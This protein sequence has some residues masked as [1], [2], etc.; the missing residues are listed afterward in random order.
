[1]QPERPACILDP[2]HRD[3]I[4]VAVVGIYPR[5]AF[6][7][8]V[9][10]SK[11]GGDGDFDRQRHHRGLLRRAHRRAL[12]NFAINGI[13]ISTYLELIIAFASIKQAAALSNRALGLLDETRAKAIVAACEEI[14]AGYLH[15]PFVVDVI[16]GGAGTST[17]MNASEVIANRALELLGHARGGKT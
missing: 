16:Q 5:C 15:D 1:L 11:T 17:N 12:E 4:I 3:G 13:P 9:W 7:N 6:R 10:I 14:R 2:P 8:D